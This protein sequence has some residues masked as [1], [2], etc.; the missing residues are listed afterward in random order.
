MRNRRSTQSLVVLLALTLLATG[1]A[2]QENPPV[3]ARDLA[4]GVTLEAADVLGDGEI[5]GWVTRRVVREGEALRPPAIAP[6]EMVRSG[7]T[8]QGVW[9][10]GGMEIRV[11][12]RA[13][14]SAA[15]GERV[16][17]RV[18]ARRRFEGVA[19]GSGVVRLDSPETSRE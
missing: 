6:P 4:R 12:G 8:V 14:N 17:V 3:A 19:V 15:E 18:D 10:Q 5:V 1:A 16:S 7:D 11:Q 13:M 2:A 9:R